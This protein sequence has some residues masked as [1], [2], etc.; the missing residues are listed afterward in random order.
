VTPDG[1]ALVVRLSDVSTVVPRP[2]MPLSLG[3]RAYACLA[4]ICGGMV[5]AVTVF[6]SSQSS[7]S[8]LAAITSL[9]R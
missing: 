2:L 9:H 4:A 6:V 8:I 1:H 7:G 3:Q 5:V